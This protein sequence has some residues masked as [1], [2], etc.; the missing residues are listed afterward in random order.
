MPPSSPR[1]N[2]KIKKGYYILDEKDRLHTFRIKKGNLLWYIDGNLM[3]H[4]KRISQLTYH[5]GKLTGYA[6]RNVIFS[7]M[8]SHRVLNKISSSTLDIRLAGFPLSQIEKKK[9]RQSWTASLAKYTTYARNN[10]KGNVYVQMP[11]SDL[12]S[13]S[14]VEVCHSK[15]VFLLSKIG[16]SVKTFVTPLEGLCC[17]LFC[18]IDSGLAFEKTPPTLRGRKLCIEIGDSGILIGHIIPPRLRPDQ[19]LKYCKPLFDLIETLRWGLAPI[20]IPF[21]LGDRHTW[22][23]GRCKN[24]QKFRLFAIHSF[25]NRIFPRSVLKCLWGY[26]CGCTRMLKSSVLRRKKILAAV[27]H[28]EFLRRL[29]TYIDKCCKHE[30][31]SSV[32]SISALSATAMEIQQPVPP[33]K[34]CDRPRPRHSQSLK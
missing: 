5:N 16:E 8:N 17:T 18:S 13:L 1:E 27:S 24:C 31:Q 11:G 29:D 34:S 20:S 9:L 22:P 19:Y 2:L 32:L 3:N 25:R 7:T 33:K 28:S 14:T 21:N 30:Q 12:L 6:G 15:N 26:S 23:A 10:Y 4:K